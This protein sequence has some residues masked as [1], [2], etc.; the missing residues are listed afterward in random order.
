MQRGGNLLII[1]M[2]GDRVQLLLLLAFSNFDIH[3]YSHLLE[4]MPT[5]AYMVLKSIVNWGL[6]MVPPCAIGMFESLS[7]NLVCKNIHILK[8][9]LARLSCIVALGYVKIAELH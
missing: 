4:K 3:E 9:T 1:R 7:G 5:S 2:D 6:N 8:F